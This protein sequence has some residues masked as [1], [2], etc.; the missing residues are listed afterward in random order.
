VKA[1]EAKPAEVFAIEDSVNKFE[2]LKIN[3]KLKQILKENSFEKLTNIQRN[4]IPKILNNRNVVLKSETGSGKTLAYLVP[5]IEF[6]SNYSL[7][8]NKIHRENS[9]TMAIIFSP[10]RE[11]AM[12]IDVEL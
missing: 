12:Q 8:V 5:L 10:T 9:G 2:D 1:P 7:N 11:L 4:A 6:L 3:D